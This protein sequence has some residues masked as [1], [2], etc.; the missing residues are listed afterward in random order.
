MRRG[1]QGW[2]SIRLI[3]PAA[4][5]ALLLGYIG[6]GSSAATASR[7]TVRWAALDQ[8]GQDLVWR[9]QLNAPFTAAGLAQQHET[10]CLLIESA[11]NGAITEQVCVVPTRRHAALVVSDG[12]QSRTIDATI[13]RPSATTLRAEFLP[14]AIGL[15]YGE[16]GW[17]TQ[18]TTAAPACA[19]ASPC[20]SHFPSRGDVLKLHTPR[21]VGCRVSGPSYVVHGPRRGR[22]IALTID[23]GPSAQTPQFLDVLER[24]HVVATFFQIGHQ[25][26]TYGQHGALDR[27]MLRDGDMIGDHTWNYGPV[28]GGGAPAASQIQMAASA[29]R[30]ASGGFTPCLFRAPDGFV[31]AA[32]IS[33]AR[34]LGY[35]TI[36]WDIDTWDWT[37]PGT[38]A[39]YNSVVSKTRPGTIV[40]EHDGGGNRSETLAALPR[41]I[42]TLR[43]RGYQFV[44]VTQLLGYRLIYK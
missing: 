42:D 11:S 3:C 13:T 39:I 35:A 30:G 2:R 36:Q 38:G 31:S 7:P 1:V 15:S 21:L 10:L 27:R 28:L 37:R 23:D 17:Q 5:V 32:L 6:A 4:V 16:L 43:H 33:E 19:S 29:I 40:L 8:S 22:M 9:A 20:T 24:N 41:E 25:I 18:I 12:G 14:G 26:S 44:S 34:R